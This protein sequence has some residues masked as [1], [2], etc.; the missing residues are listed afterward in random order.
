MIGLLATKIV[1]SHKQGIAQ[2]KE[3][4]SKNLPNAEVIK[5]SS[6]AEPDGVEISWVF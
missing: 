4:L 3:W 2:G 6:T 1:Y 5:V